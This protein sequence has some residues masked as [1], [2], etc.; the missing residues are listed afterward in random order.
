L[1]LAIISDLADG[2]IA[3]NAGQSSAAG[4]LLDHGCDAFYVVTAL[5]ALSYV[6]MVPIL[7][8]VLIALAFIQ[9]VLDSSALQGHSLRTNKLGRYNGIAYF[10]LLTV[11][12]FANLIAPSGSLQPLINA[13]AWILIVSTLLS[14]TDRL[15]TLLT[16]GTPQ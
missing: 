6:A 4:G 8:P 13:L 16:A 1:A 15:W 11:A 9:Y 10:V 12:L 5:L 14:M 3:R 2:P 7:L